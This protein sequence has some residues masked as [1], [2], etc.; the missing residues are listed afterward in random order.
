MNKW[1][2]DL[3]I[4]WKL[5][6]GFGIA[7]VL[8]LAVTWRF[9]SGLTAVSQGY[10]RLLNTSVTQSQEGLAKDILVAVLQA[11]RSEKDFLLRMELSYADK[12]QVQ[13]KKV[14]ELA[15]SLGQNAHTASN[16][17]GE[18]HAVVI[19]EKI[20]L[21][22]Q[23]FTDLVKAWQRKGLTP[24][25]GLLGGFRTAAHRL[26]GQLKEFDVEE[27][28]TLL[29]EARRAEKD[30]RL[31]REAK[32][33]KRHQE[34]SLQIEKSLSE[35]LLGADNRARVLQL[36]QP[37]A[38]T[39]AQAAQEIARSGQ[40]ATPET[41]RRL[42]ETAH[43]LEHFLNSL[44]VEN[45]WRTY[46]QARR[47]EKDYLARK[48]EKYVKQVQRYV[49]QFERDLAESQVSAESKAQLT[50]LLQEYQTTF[51]AMVGE[52][53]QLQTLEER[54][55]EAVHAV[56]GPVVATLQHA[57]EE[58][59]RAA[60]ATRQLATAIRDQALGLALLGALLG[61]L[62]SWLLVSFILDRVKRL[63][64]FAA[65]LDTGDLMA[66]CEIHAHDELGQVA[67]SLNMAMV[68][69]RAA[70]T[71]IRDAADEMRSGNV[72]LAHTATVMSQGS[73]VQAS[74]VQEVSSAMEEMSG[75]IVR[76]TENARVT[77]E[78][79]QLA[80][81][82]AVKGGD[83]VRRA[84]GAMRE[85]AGKISIIEE[86][87]RQTNLLALNAAI[88]AARAGE[89]GKGFAVVAAEVRKLAERSQSAAA[90]IGQLSGS[91]VEVAEQAG[92]IIE[93]LVPDIQKTAHL[94]Q[95]ITHASEEQNQGVGQINQAV[96][97]L[98]QMIQANAETS[99]EVSHSAE[100][101]R[102]NSE[103]LVEAVSFFRTDQYTGRSA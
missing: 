17:A 40:D 30:L 67:E 94:V 51:L 6:M 31:R 90:E 99:G 35:S 23:S 58:Q 74:S 56:D 98:D 62:V 26:E 44:Y 48:E 82:D 42:S 85:I 45:G 53:Q 68:K 66:R 33:A 49:A 50:R 38:A 92:G 20:T 87:A 54:M 8:F 12:V 15:R 73:S 89:H 64:G 83:A 71:I 60:V 63:S 91:S 16:A 21:Y 69:L 47:A 61:T 7:G 19:Q 77:Q 81:R 3:S 41:A 39:F 36:Y 13:V 18:R 46:L 37:Y 43:Q 78:I 79:S 102:H 27:L 32:Y 25:S 75:S 5:I 52:D 65:Q 103:V 76:N 97:T 55:K 100:M 86:I 59:E 72:E 9:H 88:E 96:Q 34:L 1:V 10:E 80:S 22:S 57:E 70:F 29:L 14:Q 4:R 2:R 101:L 11:R 84:V 93:K 95:E 24:E 28:R